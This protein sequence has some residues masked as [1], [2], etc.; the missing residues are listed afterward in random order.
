M[1][2]EVY[3]LNNKD[4]KYIKRQFIKAKVKIDSGFILDDKCKIFDA[5]VD[6]RSIIC[7]YCPDE[8]KYCNDGIFNSSSGIFFILEDDIENY[9]GVRRVAA[10]D[11]RSH[12]VKT[13]NENYYKHKHYFKFRASGNKYYC[14]LKNDALIS[15][16]LF[17]NEIARKLKDNEELNS[18]EKDFI[19]CEKEDLKDIL[20]LTDFKERNFDNIIEAKTVLSKIYNIIRD[21]KVYLDYLYEKIEM[22]T[23]HIF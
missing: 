21:T 20:E 19:F 13:L 18:L 16:K 2:I 4:A 10:L 22:S 9:G 1:S 11:E 14:Y 7:K 12:Y 23:N 5:Y 15:C 6:T 17:I 8:L 3:R